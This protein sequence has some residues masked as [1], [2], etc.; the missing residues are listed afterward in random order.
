[1]RCPLRATT[2][3]RTAGRGKQQVSSCQGHALRKALPSRC[4]ACSWPSQGRALAC[5][6]TFV[7]IP[8]EDC[9]VASGGGPKAWQLEQSQHQ[10]GGG[11]LGFGTGCVEIG[12]SRR[13]KGRKRAWR[14]CCSSR[15]CGGVGGGASRR[16]ESESGRLRAC[17]RCVAWCPVLYSPLNRG[18]SIES[19]VGSLGGGRTSGRGQKAHI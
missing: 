3:T 19:C 5:V 2:W 7:S 9:I 4:I 1:M 15:R 11:I 13:K 10:G 14:K 18:I 17:V 12:N 8:A 16:E 6:R